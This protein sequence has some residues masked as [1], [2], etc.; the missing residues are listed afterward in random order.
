MNDIPT[1]DKTPDAEN[2]DPTLDVLLHEAIGGPRP[3]D[4]KR[5]ILSQLRATAQQPTAQQRGTSAPPVVRAKQ[6]NRESNSLRYA[7]MT[8][9]VAASIFIV[10][11]LIQ[12]QRNGGV[13]KPGAGEMADGKLIAPAASQSGRDPGL[14]IS[15]N[16]RSLAK[17][18]P[19]N[20]PPMAVTDETANNAVASDA[21]DPTGPRTL[22]TSPAG[23]DVLPG[24]AGDRVLLVDLLKTMKP[25][26][27]E[28]RDGSEVSS[29]VQSTLIGYWSSVGVTPTVPLSDAQLSDTLRGRLGVWFAREQINDLAVVRRQITIPDNAKQL[30]RRFLQHLT[31]RGLG[32]VSDDQHANLRKL[33]ADCFKGNARLDMLLSQLVSGD[34]SDSPQFYTS[35]SHGGRHGMVQRMASV[36]MNQDVRCFRCHDGFIDARGKQSDYWSFAGMMFQSLHHDAGSGRFEVTAPVESLEEPAGNSKRSLLPAGQV[37][38]D[39]I[40]GRRVAVRP[41]LP[42]SWLGAT[43]APPNDRAAHANSIAESTLATWGPSLRGSRALAGGLVNVIWRMVHD[44]PLTQSVADVNAA[45]RDAMLDALHATLADDLVAS[46]FDIAR[47]LA[48]VI[49]SPVTRRSVADPYKVESAGQMVDAETQ[50]AYMAFAAA[51]PFFQRRSIGDRLETILATSGATL[52]VLQDGGA[53][54]AQPIGASGSPATLERQPNDRE[55]GER[56]EIQDFPI[57]QSDLPVAWLASIDDPQSRLGHVCFMAGRTGVPDVVAEANAAME[58]AGI[59]EPLRLSRLWWMIRP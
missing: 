12:R 14:P 28:L 11:I 29:D 42:S 18:I 54:L 56:I 36:T 31:N 40:D 8:F 2:F 17:D 57:M 51:K 50:Q 27:L 37:F 22:S 26:V 30:S 15:Q 49:T 20:N 59:D 10:A 32:T 23:T 3:P 48:L 45:P 47:T 55:A 25:S 4:M 44:R 16:A 6:D 33:V 53:L 19:V 24:D 43:N 35:I 38:Y 52:S 7:L 46:N 41:G 13:G 21:T 1:P 34:H 39:A 5:E 9:A 58:A